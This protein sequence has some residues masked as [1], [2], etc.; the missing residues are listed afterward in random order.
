M[1]R[2]IDHVYRLWNE[3]VGFESDAYLSKNLLAG[4]RHVLPTTRGFLNGLRSCEKTSERWCLNN[5]CPCALVCP[6]LSFLTG[7]FPISSDDHLFQTLY[8]TMCNDRV[9]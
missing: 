5:R 7:V 1:S 4:H 2:D 8:V 3:D 9:H 6:Y